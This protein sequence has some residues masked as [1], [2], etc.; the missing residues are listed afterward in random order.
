MSIMQVLKITGCLKLLLIIIW[1]KEKKHNSKV[2]FE[3]LI[4]KHIISAIWKGSQD[5]YCH[6]ISELLACGKKIELR[7]QMCK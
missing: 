3:W 4:L 7:S 6:T 1:Q 2:T 5:F